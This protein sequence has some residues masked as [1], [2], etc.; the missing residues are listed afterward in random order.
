MIKALWMRVWRGFK[1]LAKTGANS[2]ER[3]GCSRLPV[4]HHTGNS[5]CERVP[6]NAQCVLCVGVSV[7]LLSVKEKFRQKA[8][9]SCAALL[10]TGQ[11]G[12]TNVNLNLPVEVL[13]LRDPFVILT[14]SDWLSTGF[15]QGVIVQVASVLRFRKQFLSVLCYRLRP[16][17][18]CSK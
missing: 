16:R 12:H 15:M 2:S 1:L 11:I 9:S 10:I 18:G 7:Y 17:K 4:L 8:L 14:L 3:T 13:C 5:R 6:S